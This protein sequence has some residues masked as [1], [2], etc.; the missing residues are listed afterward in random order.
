[1]ALLKDAKCELC[2][3]VGK[4]NNTA[5]GKIYLNPPLHATFNQLSKYVMVNKDLTAR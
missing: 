5:H 4:M 1:M 2:F 3:I